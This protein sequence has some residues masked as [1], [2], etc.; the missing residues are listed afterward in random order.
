LSYRSIFNNARQQIM[1]NVLI[2]AAVLG[3]VLAI[4]C[5]ADPRFAS[6]KVTSVPADAHVFFDGQMRGTTPIEIPGI[7]PGKHQLVVRKNGY[8]RF[9]QY[10]TFEAGKR[11]VGNITLDTLTQAEIDSARVADSLQF[12]RRMESRFPNDSIP[13]KNAYVAV[14]KNPVPLIMPQP[15]YPDEAKSAGI[16][17]KVF[18]QILIDIDGHVVRADVAKSSGDQSLDDAAVAA[19]QQWKF[20]PALAPCNKPVRVWVMQAFTFRVN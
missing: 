20:S 1:T 5:H 13:D 4:A 18:I 15:E 12:V 7:A 3:C 14:D 16:G 17:G 2:K 9:A 11:Q 6:L 19:A 10:L 8:R